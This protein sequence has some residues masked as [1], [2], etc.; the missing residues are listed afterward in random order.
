MIKFL[1]L[2][3]AVEI[4]SEFETQDL[5]NTLSNL[6]QLQRS[7]IEENLK[8]PEGSAGRIMNRDFLSV[9]SNLSVGS[10]LTN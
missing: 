10:L 7:R 3:D 1:D 5:V 9:K 4:L 8:Y 6:G 2:D